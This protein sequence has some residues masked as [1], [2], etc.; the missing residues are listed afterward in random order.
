MAWRYFPELMPLKQEPNI[1]RMMP[2][3]E[4]TGS[5]REPDINAEVDLRPIIRYYEDFMNSRTRLAAL[6]HDL[7]PTRTFE[8]NIVMNAYDCGIP[9][10]LS[11]MST[12][13]EVQF[14]SFVLQLERNYG[15][16]SSYARQAIEMWANA[17]EVM[18]ITNDDN[19]P[20]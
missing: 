16:Q 1:Q 14:S 12:L 3:A 7:F 13:D 2:S 8:T 18:I 17:F 10:K 5:I 15:L 9:Q 6:L 11:R 19:P 20:F 4:N